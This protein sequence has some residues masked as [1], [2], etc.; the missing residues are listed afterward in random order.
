MTIGPLPRMRI[1]WM[2]SRLGTARPSR[3]RRDRL[4]EAVE[5]VERVVGPGASLGVVLDRGAVDVE[6]L[7][8]L[9]GAVVEVDVRERG[10]AEV[11]APADRLVGLDAAAAVGRRDREPVV[12]RRDLD[13]A[14]PQVLD[15]MVGPAVPEGQLVGL[16]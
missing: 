16:E 2:S 13:L 5:L 7:Q 14:R 6:K 4:Q 1:L 15:R 8:A 10:V 9:D 12:L 3:S 11:G